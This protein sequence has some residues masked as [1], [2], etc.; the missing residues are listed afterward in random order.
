MYPGSHTGL[1]LSALRDT[2]DLGYSQH[3]VMLNSYIYR[4]H[5]ELAVV[6]AV[7]TPAGSSAYRKHRLA[8]PSGSLCEWSV[9][10]PQS[11]ATGDPCG[12]VC[13]AP[14]IR[15]LAGRIP[16]QISRRRRRRACPG[17]EH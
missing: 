8:P 15:A 6:V 13:A 5:S 3:S 12:R 10:L 17:T 9:A 7:H 2:F 16:F 4:A 11:H 1:K 14:V